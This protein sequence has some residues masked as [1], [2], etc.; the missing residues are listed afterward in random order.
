ME[1][2]S[3]P[4]CKILI[5][6]WWVILCRQILNRNSS[7]FE[8]FRVLHYNP[9]WRLIV[10]NLHA[11][12]RSCIQTKDGKEDMIRRWGC[13]M[14]TEGNTSNRYMRHNRF[15]KEW[16]EGAVGMRYAGRTHSMFGRDATS[17]RILP[18]WATKSPTIF[19]GI[20]NFPGS[21]FLG[22]RESPWTKTVGTTLLTKYAARLI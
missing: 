14:M 17:K 22:V 4:S 7:S 16:E 11:T 19:L 15:V 8:N 2:L 20:C 12:G 13:F 18:Y 21:G 3:R 1:I 6:T 10:P 9:S 5:M